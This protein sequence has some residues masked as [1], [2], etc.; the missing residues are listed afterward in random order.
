MDQKGWYDKNY[1]DVPMVIRSVAAAVRARYP[2]KEHTGRFCEELTRM[3]EELRPR[4]AVAV[5][6]SRCSVCE[7]PQYETPS[8]LTCQNGHGGAP[9][10]IS[11]G[12]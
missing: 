10:L 4:R 2:G 8:G 7:E 9:S 11:E 5:A 12:P 1:P 3:I 6:V